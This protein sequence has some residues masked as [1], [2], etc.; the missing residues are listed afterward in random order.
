MENGITLLKAFP[1]RAVPN[2]P[3]NENRTAEFGLQFDPPIH[4]LVDSYSTDD[5]QSIRHE[6]SNM[7]K[8][9]MLIELKKSIAQK[10]IQQV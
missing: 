6:L 5:S 1:F 8:E 10:A 9:A 3:N 4:S 7:T 2:K